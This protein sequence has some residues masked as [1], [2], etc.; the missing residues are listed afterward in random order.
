MGLTKS[1]TTLG[2]HRDCDIVLDDHTI[3]RYH[4][5]IR[6][7]GDGHYTLADAGSLNGT[8][9]NRRVAD[10]VALSDGDEIWIGKARFVFACPHAEH[11]QCARRK[12]SPAHRPAP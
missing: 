2:R 8:Y 6:H 5:E 3:S 9:V 11:E 7:D 10:H 12:G 4:A 1:L